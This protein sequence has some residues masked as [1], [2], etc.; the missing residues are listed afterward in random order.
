MGIIDDL[1]PTDQVSSR[2]L[3]F[4]VIADPHYGV[5][6]RLGFVGEPDP[7]PAYNQVAEKIIPTHNLLYIISPDHTIR[8]TQVLPST[9]GFNVLDVIRSIHALQTVD[10]YDV[11]MPAD[12]SPGRDAVMPVGRKRTKAAVARLQRDVPSA[13]EPLAPAGVEAG[14]IRDKDEDGLEYY[15]EGEYQEEVLDKMPPGE[16][17]EVLPYL[18]YVRIDDRVENSASV[19]GYEKM[20]TDLLKSFERFKSE[21]AEKRHSESERRKQRQRDDALLGLLNDTNGMRR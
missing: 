13:A 20:R 12:W 18:R 2:V 16:V 9:L 11:L 6:K 17:W 1:E 4:P 10:D 3:G 5:H 7:P 14:V 15:E 8:L 21:Q 19:I